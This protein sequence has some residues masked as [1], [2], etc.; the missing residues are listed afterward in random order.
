MCRRVSIAIWSTGRDRPN[1]RNH[2]ISPGC[3]FDARVAHGRPP[4]PRLRARQTTTV[5]ATPVA[6]AIAAWPTAPHPAPPPYATSL[7]YARLG[8]PRLRTISTSIVFS[9]ENFTRPSTS[10]AVR[11]ASSSAILMASSAIVRSGRPMFFENS[12]WPMPTMAAASR[13]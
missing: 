4:E 8:M 11:P 2:C 9:C 12:V 7:K 6:I 5:S 3:L 10:F 13:G 1:G